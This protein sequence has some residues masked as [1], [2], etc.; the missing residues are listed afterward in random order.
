MSRLSRLKEKKNELISLGKN[1]EDK[2]FVQIILQSLP[3]SYQSFIRGLD[4][5]DNLKTIKSDE[6]CAKLIEEEKCQIKEK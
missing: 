6:V 2:D 5:V 3:S 1:I 4:T